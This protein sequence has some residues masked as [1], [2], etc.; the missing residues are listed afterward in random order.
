MKEH[1]F[2]SLRITAVLLAITCG[3][4]PGLVWAV[5]QLA[6]RDQADGSLVTNRGRVV[7]SKLI[8]QK[9]EGDRYF[10]SR[11]SAS[12]YDATASGGSN[13]GPTSRKL[14]ERITAATNGATNV[15]ADAVMMSA[16]G[17]D[18]HISPANALRQASRVARA[19][20]IDERDLRS[21]IAQHTEHRF[22]GIFGEPRVNVLLLNLALDRGVS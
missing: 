18:P 19:R 17:L 13:L 14:S 4:Y 6:F 21:L 22:L 20:N 8:G 5:G 12:G 15:P 2:V 10:H 16:S 3:I 7:G 1:V 11:P 9:F